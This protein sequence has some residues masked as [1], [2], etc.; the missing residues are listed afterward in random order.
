MVT[1]AKITIRGTVQGVG[2]R[3]Y[4]FKK[5]QRSKLNGYVA[6]TPTGVDIEV[7]GE[8][9]EGFIETLRTDAPPLSSIEEA[10]MEVLPPRGYHGFSIRDSIDG[11][12][13]FTLISPD[14]SVC[15]DCL[16]E[17]TDPNDRRYL[18]P[19]I[20]CTN[21][22]P[23]Y[24]I[25]KS[26]PY[27]RKNTTMSGFQMCSDCRSE[28]GNPEDR[29]FHAEAIACEKCGPV[30]TLV[31]VNRNYAEVSTSPVESVIR[32]LKQGAVVAVKG[33]G[34]FH[35]VCNALDDNAV[36]RLREKKMRSH[37]PFAMMAAA[38]NSIKEFAHV[39]DKEEELL[40]SLRRPIVLLRK[41][42]GTIS[43]QVS[44][45][46]S[47][48]GFMLPYTPLH[49]LLFY[50]PLDNSPAE[51]PH[52]K[53]LVMTS[54]N[55][56]G[57]PVIT[58]NDEAVDKL[59]AVADAILLNDRDIY[60]GCDDS[61]LRV[62]QDGSP[63]IIRRARGYAAQ[64]LLLDRD[65]PEIVAY[66]SDLKN[67]FTLVKRSHAILSTYHGDMGNVNTIEFFN[68]NLKTMS[69][70]FGITPT[71]AAC[72]A[73]P[74]YVTRA[75]TAEGNAAEIILIQHHHAHALSVMAEHGL[76]GEAIA[77]VL[78]GTGYGAD[79]SVWGGEFLVAGMDGFKR[80][81]HLKYVPLPGG[82][83]AVKEPRRMAVSYVVDAFEDEAKDALTSLGF[84]GRHGEEFI[85]SII[86]IIPLR[87]FSPLTSSA[88]RL[89]DA[90]SSILGLAH[91]NTYEGQ[92][93]MELE[94]IIT[95]GVSGSYPFAISD[96][97]IVDFSL[98]IRAVVS[99]VTKGVDRGTVAAIFHNTVVAAVVDIVMRLSDTLGLRDI[100]LSGGVFQNAYL[101]NNTI[102]RL[103]ELGLN[104]FT[105]ERVPCNDGG[106]SLGQ[107][108]GA[109]FMAEGRL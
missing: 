15:G 18:Y 17:L 31:L 67:T 100:L 79:G 80:E 91:I 43:P 98:A 36:R 54:G 87:E 92:A 64:A 84:I 19:F 62:R 38:I 11:P 76:T 60:M 48:H 47:L 6:N 7:E 104:V 68:R 22:G 82:E 27:D 32:L 3:P 51:V 83:M 53:S 75:M 107:A 77:V 57:E 26:V 108:Y 102:S 14:I 2:F 71:I 37:K 52:F 46:V 23:R 42:D 101:L 55:Y 34:G 29:R 105:N 103:R 69:S 94:S 106:I 49:Y 109:R 45:R 39:S 9:A 24:S 73:H 30:L 63:I 40:T 96:D 21:C 20:N 56:S 44:G 65:C 10:S 81:G 95:P 89:F 78:D 41:K 72:D 90:V 5:A 85:D 1:L 99:D 12:P 16:D 66:G 61:V 35:L 28:Y 70:I 4:V 8:D 13:P 88:G 33:I 93:P 25:I 50:H 58:C 86:R 74:G 97:G 59:S